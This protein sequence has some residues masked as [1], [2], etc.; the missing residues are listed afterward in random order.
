MI[1]GRQRSTGLNRLRA[2]GAGQFQCE[3]CHKSC[4]SWLSPTAAPLAQRRRPGSHLCVM[5]GGPCCFREP[6]P[7]GPLD[8]TLHNC[9]PLLPAQ[10]QAHLAGEACPA[11][12]S[13]HPPALTTPFADPDSALPY[14]HG[15]YYLPTCCAIYFLLLSVPPPLL[16]CKPHEGTFIHSVPESSTVPGTWYV[17][18][19]YH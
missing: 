12:C 3:H 9:P 15:I 14:L 18:N 6:V 13:L 19:A 17:L 8:Q 4:R 1:P 7:S 2:E 16:E 5:P 11:P 10:L